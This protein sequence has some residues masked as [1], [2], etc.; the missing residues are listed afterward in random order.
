MDKEKSEAPTN[1]SLTRTHTERRKTYIRLCQ[2][3]L[4]SKDSDDAV[5]SSEKAK[6]LIKKYNNLSNQ[7]M[8]KIPKRNSTDEAIRTPQLN[9]LFDICLLVGYNYAT[10]KPY[11]KMKHPAE[12]TC[13]PNIE[14]TIFPSRVID[15]GVDRQEFSIV[16]TDDSGRKFAFCR[17]VLPEN[18]ETCLPLTYCLVTQENAP[19]FYFKILREIELCH[20][21]PSK[22]LTD[23]LNDLQAKEIPKPGQSLQFELPQL[24][25]LMKSSP[26]KAV[27]HRRLSLEATPRW[28]GA[29]SSDVDCSGNLITIARHADVRTENTD[30]HT[31]FKVTGPE[32]LLVVFEYVLMERS[33][34]L[35][36]KNISVLS[37][38]VLALQAIIYPFKW[39]YVWISVIPENMGE[40]I[41]SPVPLLAGTLVELENYVNEGVYVDLDRCVIRKNQVADEVSLL[42]SG[43]AKSLKVTLD[44][45]N[46][47][48]KDQEKSTINILLSEAFI[49]FFVELFE[50][51][52]ASTFNVSNYKLINYP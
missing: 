21:Q 9:Q 3:S 12:A 36:S 33:V 43:L 2:Q 18:F 37:S 30:I 5:P 15:A 38:C 52:D 25:P 22:Y 34:I 39:R 27:N 31:L 16:L 7:S 4:K 32:I 44:M 49:R 17:R 23:L 35:H 28:L 50:K 46:L 51:F 42:P 47:I 40:L 41:D 14:Y 24:N 19:G 6:E 13:P 1:I 26:A 45:V 20:G 8:K 11:I 10:D 48:S 29:N